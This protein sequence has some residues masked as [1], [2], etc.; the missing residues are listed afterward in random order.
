MSVRRGTWPCD[1]IKVQWRHHAKGSTNTVCPCLT[2][3]GIGKLRCGVIVAH[4]NVTSSKPVASPGEGGQG[5]G[6]GLTPHPQCV[7]QRLHKEGNREIREMCVVACGYVTSSKSRNFVRSNGQR[8]KEGDILSLFHVE[9]AARSDKRLSWPVERVGARVRLTSVRIPISGTG[10]GR[11][12]HFG[13]LLMCS[14]A[15]WPVTH[16]D[17]STVVPCPK[18]RHCTQRTCRPFCFI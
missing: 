10:G 13:S 7:G 12:G 5:E 16:P 14:P 18:V 17:A 3:E 11:L 2:C 9:Q 4:G 1:V 15:S 6:T 8:A